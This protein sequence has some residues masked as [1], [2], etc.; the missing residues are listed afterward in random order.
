MFPI[1]NGMFGADRLAKRLNALVSDGQISDWHPGRWIDWGH[2]SIQIDFD[3]VADAALAKQLL[4]CLRAQ[5][6]R[7]PEA[8]VGTRTQENGALPE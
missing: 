7:H 2:T 4:S 3:S 8:P 5:R 1:E 6:G